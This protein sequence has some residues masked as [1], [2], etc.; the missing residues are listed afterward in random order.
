MAYRLA[1]KYSQYWLLK[2]LFLI[3]NIESSINTREMKNVKDVTVQI[4]EC[5]SN[6]LIKSHY[7][8]ASDIELSFARK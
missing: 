7:A 5:K 6:Q 1:C 2:C 3:L 8:V 4:I